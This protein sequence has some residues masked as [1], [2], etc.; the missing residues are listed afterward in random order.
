MPFI[1]HHGEFTIL[2]QCFVS[3]KWTQRI[4]FLVSFIALLWTTILVSYNYI[5]VPLPN[6]FLWV[7]ICMLK[8]CKNSSHLQL[9][10]WRSPNAGWKAG[11]IWKQ[12]VE[13]DGTRVANTKEGNV[14][15]DTLSQ[16][17]GPL[18]RLQGCG[19][20]DWQ[21]HFD[22]LCNSTKVV[23]KTSEMAKH[24]GFVQCGHLT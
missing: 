19:G 22:V 23:I 1:S 15:H 20:L 16:D 4:I 7:H 17:L 12:E 5:V 18:H 8:V 6:G 24:I 13:W 2:P 21:R 14:G 11:G 3:S 10:N 9:C